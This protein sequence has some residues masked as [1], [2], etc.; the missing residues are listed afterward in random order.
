MPS[1]PDPAF[2]FG[3]D[4]DDSLETPT[5]DQQPEHPPGALDKSSWLQARKVFVGGIP[6]TVDQNGLY[7]MFSKF[8]KVK[9]AWLQL[10]HPDRVGQANGAK[11]HRGFGF[12]VFYEKHSL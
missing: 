2:L 11:K 5:L 7:Q 4:F 10:F 1:S 9:K 6:Q 12:V 8:G 3:S